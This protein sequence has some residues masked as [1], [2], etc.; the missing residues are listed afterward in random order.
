MYGGVASRLVPPLLG[1]FA[2][3]SR[4]RVALAGLH[5]VGCLLSV[6][7][8]PLAAHAESQD[9]A[10]ARAHFAAGQTYFEQQLYAEAAAEF[11]EAYHLSGRPEM[12]INRARAE[13]RAGQLDNSLTSLELLFERH[14]QTS[15]REEAELQME[16]LRAQGAK[17]VREASAASEQPKPGAP[18]PSPSVQEKQEAKLWPPRLPTLIVG[19]LLV[20]SAIVSVGTG[21]AAHSKYQHLEARCPEDRCPEAYDDFADD[22]R[23]GRRLA[24][25]STGFTIASVAL[26]AA[27]VALWVY[28]AK[29]KKAQ[30]SLG[31]QTSLHGAGAQLRWAY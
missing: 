25:T 1:F 2:S 11:S 6:V 13:E 28:D 22:K 16:R 10:R 18:T 14:P 8:S 17:S 3:V 30:L 12:L 15:Y 21:W 29:A 4:S 9:D 24:R 7:L 19:G 27:T 5:A 31:V 26:A 23:E 20:A